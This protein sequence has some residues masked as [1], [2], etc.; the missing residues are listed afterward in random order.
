MCSQCRSWWEHH[1]LHIVGLCIT[2]AEGTFW[3]TC[4]C[5]YISAKLA[6]AYISPRLL[7]QQEHTTV[8]HSR[9]RTSPIIEGMS[10][11]FILYYVVRFIDF[12]LGMWCIQD[13]GA[14]D[15][16]AAWTSL[17]WRAVTG[18]SLVAVSS[19]HLFPTSGLRALMRNSKA[20]GNT[21]PGFNS[22]IRPSTNVLSSK[23][24][25]VDNTKLTSFHK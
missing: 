11:P 5:I 4:P 25:E 2:L 20:V 16:V 7:Q 6:R 9:S 13:L 3:E 1:E 8:T 24:R 12:D 18:A 10:A 14:N 22:A 15:I 21:W 19:W 17:L 23:F